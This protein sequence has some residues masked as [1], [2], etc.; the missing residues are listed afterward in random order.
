MPAASVIMSSAME[1]EVRRWLMAL[2]QSMRAMKPSWK[3]SSFLLD[4]KGQRSPPSSKVLLY[5]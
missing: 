3:P 4:I 5:R 2:Q 1:V